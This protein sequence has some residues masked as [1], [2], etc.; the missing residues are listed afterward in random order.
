MF[1]DFR[2]NQFQMDFLALVSMAT[3]WSNS[4]FEE[5]LEKCC[6]SLGLSRRM[7]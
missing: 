2:V 3:K 6:A 4:A 1:K 5:N 7:L